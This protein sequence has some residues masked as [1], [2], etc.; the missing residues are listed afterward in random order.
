V[1]RARR[2]SPPPIS[3]EDLL[4][5]K[6]VSD[7]QISPDGQQVLY[8]LTG[9]DSDKDRYVSHLWMAPADGAG[10]PRQLTYGAQGESLPRW[11]P[12]GC[13]IAFLAAR[14]EGKEK[15][16]HL[17]PADR[18]GEAQQLTSLDWGVSGVAWAPDSQHLALV[19]RGQKSEE[20]KR[21]GRTQPGRVFDA[22]PTKFNA[23]GIH[24]DDIR[25]Q[26]YKV[27]V[28]GGSPVQVTRSAFRPDELTWSPAGDQVAFTQPADW[29][30][31][32]ELKRDLFVVPAD[33][34]R[35]K[36]LTRQPRAASH[37]CWT[38]DGRS[39]V[40]LGK[41]DGPARNAASVKLWRVPAEGGEARLIPGQGD[42]ELGQ[43]IGSDTRYGR[44]DFRLA[45][46]RESGGGEAKVWCIAERRGRA[47]VGSLSL[48]NGAWT[49]LTDGD[50]VVTSFSIAADGT[51]AFVAG[52]A[53]SP[54]DVYVLSPSGT[55]RRL[56]GANHDLLASREVSRPVE[57]TY[58]S[59]DGLECTGWVLP[60][61]GPYGQRKAPTVLE[62]HGGPHT[63]Y[64]HAF[65]HEFQV[66]AGRGYAVIF[67]NPR[68]ST[69]YGEA[70]T[71]GVVGDYGGMDY[72]D[73]TAGV[74]AAIA[75]FPF[76]D[77]RRLG[78][79]GGS[80]GGFMTN[81]MVTQS[82]RF[83][84]AVTRR[85][86]SNWISMYGTSDIGPRFTEEEVGG[87]PWAGHDLLWDRSPL[88]HVDRIRTPLLIIHADEDHRCP[89]EQ[90]EQLF[91]AL[92][93]R[94]RVCRFLRFPGENHELTRSGTP[95]R[96]LQNQREILAW[97]DAHV[98]RR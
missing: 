49:P 9:I 41:P 71:A 98:R 42:L 36:R 63:A 51:V 73:L 87:D 19:S 40:F 43:A 24:W 13:W 70:F 12:D 83:Q 53:T 94:G 90:A 86:I 97:F 48:R 45:F 4:A 17:L 58:P 93:R 15:Q 91:V 31:Y 3:T 77:S 47:Q 39:L 72:A 66:L 61:T 60:P 33:G 25:A 7:P 81:W 74:D 14:G 55:E 28:D 89:V 68:G 29:R 37:P 62:I 54:D 8:V 57:F 6:F 27:S 46:N 88:R 92:R 82:H 10:L 2:R 95:S 23:E 96:R 59:L 11:S 80:Y 22:F 79:T 75:K 21:L 78:V 50:R 69:G 34:G 56:T 5:F 1:T 16:L 18:P 84:G 35:I 32:G 52:S 26:V 20:E 76:I 85:S 38:P 64:G 65:F 30:D 67:L 44:H